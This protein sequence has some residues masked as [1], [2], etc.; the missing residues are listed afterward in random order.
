MKKLL[1]VLLVAL[2]LVIGFTCSPGA[3]DHKPTAYIDAISPS[4]A[5]QGVTINFEGHGT[6]L[7]HDIAAYRWRSNMD[8][9]LSVKEYFDTSSLSEGVHTVYFKVQ[10]ER[11][12][13]SDEAIGTVS[14]SGDAFA[15]AV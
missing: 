4:E 10:C 6:D 14:I 3:N 13:W 7:A 1:F 12:T 5:S 9:E 11:G 8:G 2:T 15:G